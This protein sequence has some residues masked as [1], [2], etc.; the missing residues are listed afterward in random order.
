MQTA[1]LERKPWEQKKG[2]HPQ[3]NGALM[4]EKQWGPSTGEIAAPQKN[5]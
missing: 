4:S 1:T 2:G 3:K 5:N